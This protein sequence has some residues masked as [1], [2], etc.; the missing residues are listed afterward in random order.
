MISFSGGNMKQKRIRNLL[1]VVSLV[2][3][4]FLFASLVIAAGPGEGARGGVSDSTP[5]QADP[6]DLTEGF[7]DITTLPGLGWFM[8]NNSS[9]LGVTGWFQGNDTVFPAQAGATT[10]YIGA[11]YNN[12]AGTGTISNWLLTPVLNLNDGDTVSFWTRTATGT[13]WPDRLELRMSTNGASTN[14]GTLATDVGDFTTVITTV[15][16]TLIVSGYPQV[17]TEYVET[18]S[19]V[20]TPT[21][22]RL[23][24][25]YWVTDGGPSGANSNYI[26]IDTFTFTD[27][28]PPSAPGIAISI[29]PE[30]QDVT[31][32]GIADFTITVTNTGDVDLANVN[33][34]DPLVSDCDNAIGALVISATVSYACQDTAVSA[35]YTNVVTVTSDLAAGGAGPSASDS[36]VVN[37]LSPTSVSLTGFGEGAMSLMPIWLG[38]LVLLVVGLGFV[39]RR[40]LTA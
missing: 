38:A 13:L 28:T 26:G 21:D 19:G 6:A 23:A 39:L 33:V 30:T 7:N 24:F 17:W 40:K 5:P 15:N 29:S 27:G 2:M 34:A 1:F 3:A 31:T 20:P 35:S 10:S 36:A 8:Q 37:Y 25:R 22:G 11:N 9:P 14:V 4:M 18:I 12:T 32:N 16:P